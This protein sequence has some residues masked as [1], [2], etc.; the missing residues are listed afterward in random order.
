[1]KA[2]YNYRIYPKQSQLTPLAKAFGSSRVVWNDA[3][4]LYKNAERNKLDRPTKISNLVITQAKKTEERS[5]LSEVS[6]VV[7]QQSLRDLQQA[8]DNYFSSLKGGR[9][10]KAVG[11]P[12]P[13]KKHSRQAIRFASNAFSVHSQ[14]VYL[15]KIGHVKVV[16]SRPLPSQPTSVTV[17][18]D[19]T[20]RYFASFV[21]EIPEQI[22]YA[23]R[24]PLG[25]QTS[26][27]C[28]IDLGLTH[29][30]ILST[31]EKIENPR[32]HKKM[33][34]KIKLANRRLAKAKRD[35][36]RRKKRKLRLA[37]LHVKVKDARTDFLH[38]LTTRLVRENQALAVE[39]LN[40][41]GMVKNR[42]LSRAISD[43]GWSKFKTM[44]EAKCD[45]YGRDLTIVDRWYPSSQICSCC[46]KS[47]GKKELDVRQWQCLF[48]N[49]THDRDLNASINLSRWAGGQSDQYKN[50]RGASVSQAKLAVCGEALTNPIQLT[51]F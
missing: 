23:E 10:G 2:R 51:L 45:K 32:L 16:F 47:G 31:G 38:K 27:S 41:A 17:I 21:V 40:V 33:L 18:K 13:K 14:S 44:L 43:A 35:S 39:D 5:W 11:R 29:F 8:W 12:K 30:A 34:K 15:A 36:N 3:W 46:G 20:G 49:T 19:T 1:M 50:E 42:K 6:S 4:W 24:Y 9:K 28:G 7:L 48:C 37:K 25:P 22:A 26:N